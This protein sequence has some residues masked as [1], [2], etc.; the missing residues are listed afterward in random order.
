MAD[1]TT[2]TGSV[3]FLID[4]ENSGLPVS[5]SGNGTATL[6]VSALAIGSHSIVAEYNDGQEIE[7]TG[8]LTTVVSAESTN[9][10]LTSPVAAIV[11]GQTTTVTATVSANSLT[12][13]TP[14][15]SVQF[16]IDGLVSGRPS[17][18]IPPAALPRDADPPGRTSRGFR[19][20]PP[21]FGEL[22]RKR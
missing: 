5:L 6:L 22:P 21:G 19:R 18:L 20:V 13:S 17:F 12:G 2:P 14:V 7:S 8:T 3:Q 15:G 10:A 16:L 11:Y 4:G 1:G 9:T